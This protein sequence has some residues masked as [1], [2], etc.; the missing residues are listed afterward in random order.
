MTIAEV[1]GSKW[2]AVAIGKTLVVACVYV[3]T[4]SVS[5]TLNGLDAYNG[6]YGS[7]ILGTRIRDYLHGS[8]LFGTQTLQF[9]CILHLSAIYIINRCTLAEHFKVIAFL[10]HSRHFCQHL[11]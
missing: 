4:E 7:V 8:N 3:E 2:S 6:R 11:L 9:I 1:G 10:C 5:L